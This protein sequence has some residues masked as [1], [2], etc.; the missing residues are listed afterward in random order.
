MRLQGRLQRR[1]YTQ[2]EPLLA[3]VTPD[4][5][6][7]IRLRVLVA[8]AAG[9]FE[10]LVVEPRDRSLFLLRAVRIIQ[11]HGAFVH[12]GENDDVTRSVPRAGAPQGSALLERSVKLAVGVGILE[13]QRT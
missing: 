11:I 10:Q 13:R 4:S 1:F 2:N 5:R 6:A 7:S 3:T 8:N 12:A 9:D